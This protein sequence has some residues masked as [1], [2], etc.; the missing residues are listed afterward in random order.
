LLS[1]YGVGTGL[2]TDIGVTPGFFLDLFFR[3]RLNKNMR[4]LGELIALETVY[5]KI[6]NRSSNGEIFTWF[7]LYGD[8]RGLKIQT[9]KP[10]SANTNAAQGENEFNTADL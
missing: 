4:F 1:K 10:L 5:L 8:P 6:Q 7:L 3:R 2:K 9:S